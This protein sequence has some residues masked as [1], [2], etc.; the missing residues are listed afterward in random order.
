MGTLPSIDAK[1]RPIAAPASGPKLAA[2]LDH[3]G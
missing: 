3:D 2:A 1:I